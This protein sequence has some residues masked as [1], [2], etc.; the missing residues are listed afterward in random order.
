LASL[1]V[2]YLAFAESN[3]VISERLVDRGPNELVFSD[4]EKITKMTIPNPGA[5][6]AQVQGIV[7]AGTRKVIAGV[8]DENKKLLD[9][10]N[11]K[12]TG[13]LNTFTIRYNEAL[14]AFKI[15]EGN[16]FWVLVVLAASSI[17]ALILLSVLVFRKPIVLPIGAAVS[18]EFE[19]KSHEKLDKLLVEVEEGK[20]MI[21][22]VPIQTKAVIDPKLKTLSEKMDDLPKKVVAEGA[23]LDPS[24]FI[25]EVDGERMTYQSSLKGIKEGYFL[26]LY[27]PANMSADAAK[28]D[29]EP[30]T[31]RGKA[32]RSSEKTMLRYLA[33]DFDEP[34]FR[35]QKEYIELLESKKDPDMYITIEK[36][37]K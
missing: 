33:G 34:Q 36:I 32:R 21:A 37:K 24:P 8:Q 13:L 14:T 23:K 7:S 22:Q 6:K 1:S 2:S 5:T 15:K 16:L 30:E 20:E 19:K 25:V 29:P 12:N 3:A 9:A 11:A 4:K 26:P 28:Y 10:Q 17:F 27:A 31:S 35:L 18:S